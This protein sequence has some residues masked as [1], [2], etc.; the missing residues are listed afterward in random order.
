MK[1][2][3]ENQQKWIKENGARYQELARGVDETGH[4]VSL[5]TDEVCRKSICSSTKADEAV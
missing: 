4:N 1:S 5:T 3:L 2:E